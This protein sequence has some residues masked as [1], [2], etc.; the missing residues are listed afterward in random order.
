MWKLVWVAANAGLP[1]F[2][3]LTSSPLAFCRHICPVWG[4]PREGSVMPAPSH[5]PFWVSSTPGCGLRRIC[6]N[7]SFRAALEL[8]QAPEVTEKNLEGQRPCALWNVWGFAWGGASCY[9]ACSQG[10]HQRE[11]SWPSPSEFLHQPDL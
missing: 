7:D 5:A 6:G 8:G 4:L 3:L 9:P 10:G 11:G 1:H 2:F